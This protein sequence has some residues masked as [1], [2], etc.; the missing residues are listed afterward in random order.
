MYNT[1]LPLVINRTAINV[2]LSQTLGWQL[3]SHNIHNQWTK[4]KGKGTLIWIYDTGAGK[5]IDLKNKYILTKDFTDENN[6]VDQQGHGT[7]VATIAAARDDVFGMVGTAPEAKLASMKILTSSGVGLRNWAIDGFKWQANWLKTDPRAKDYNHVINCSL[8]SGEDD[9][10]L[11][12]AVLDLID[13]GCT[14]IAAAGNSGNDGEDNVMYPGSFK[15]VITVGSCNKNNEISYFSSSGNDV[16]ICAYAEDVVGGG[17]NDSFVIKS[18]TS[19]AAPVVSGVSAMLLSYYGHMPHEEIKKRLCDTAIDIGNAGKDIA[20][21]C[22]LLNV[23]DLMPLQT[24]VEVL[25]NIMLNQNKTILNYTW[26]DIVFRWSKIRR[27]L[28]SNLHKMYRL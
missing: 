6:P 20:T 14:F 9:T 17:M 24:S 28:Q 27:E 4:S 26:W 11:H 3:R 13:L 1:K 18:G 12:L 5:H 16:D 2:S 8:G 23:N 25:E 22:G 10:M 19:F 21:G 15:E 7:F